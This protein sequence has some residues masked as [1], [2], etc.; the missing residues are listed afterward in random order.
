MRRSLG[1]AARLQRRFGSSLAAVSRLEAALFVVARG[2]NNVS[3]RS[4]SPRRRAKRDAVFDCS[5]RSLR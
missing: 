3:A 1:A 5:L 4:S 2:R